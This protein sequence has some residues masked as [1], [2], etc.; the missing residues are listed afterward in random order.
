MMQCSRNEC[1]SAVPPFPASVLG[2][3]PVLGRRLVLRMSVPFHSAVRPVRRQALLIMM[4]DGGGQ[5]G[6]RFSSVSLR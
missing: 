1:A 5:G 4:A 3:F 6:Q 2:F